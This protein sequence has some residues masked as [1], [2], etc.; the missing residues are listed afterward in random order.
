M[1]A[2]CFT[3]PVHADFSENGM[4]AADF[5]RDELVGIIRGA[6]SGFTVTQHVSP[7]HVI[8]FDENSSD[9]AICYSYMHAQRGTR[10][11]AAKDSVVT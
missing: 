5:A 1:L 6:L 3:D 7:N 4:P 9:R 8:E 10:P 2:N 11:R